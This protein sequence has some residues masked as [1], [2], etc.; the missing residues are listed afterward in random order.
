MNLDTMRCNQ[1]K[2]NCGTLMNTGPSFLNKL[3]GG[4]KEM[5]GKHGPKR[6]GE[7]P[8]TLLLGMSGS[9]VTGENG[10]VIS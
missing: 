8:S 9:V 3:K 1:Q 7:T 2:S 10:L 4:E 6:D 5:E